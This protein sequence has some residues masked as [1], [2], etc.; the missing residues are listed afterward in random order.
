[1][2]LDQ[3]GWAGGVSD[4]A[5]LRLLARSFASP[6]AAGD[7]SRSSLSHRERLAPGPLCAPSWHKH[8]GAYS[9]WPGKL[10]FNSSP[11]S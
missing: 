8:G 5:V 2:P 4:S 10:M 3:L 9:G 6:Q 11:H 7:H 1:M